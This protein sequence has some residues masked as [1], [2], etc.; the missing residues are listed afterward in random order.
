[1]SVRFAAARCR[2]PIGAGG[3]TDRFMKLARKG[4][5]VGIAAFERQLAQGSLR[6]SEPVASPVDAQPGQILA[7]GKAEYRP[8]SLIK[9]ER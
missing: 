4:R 5:L 1:M 3:E 7:G 8:D 6:V 9:L 2:P